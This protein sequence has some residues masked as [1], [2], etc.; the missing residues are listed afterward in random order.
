[1]TRYA[2]ALGS[3]VGRRLQHLKAAVE[4]ISSLGRIDGVSG[5]YET[6]PIGGPAQAP[7][8]NAV[9]G[10]ET[11]L[12]PEALLDRLRQI[13]NRRGRERMIRWGPRTLDL[14]IIGSDGPAVTDPELVIPHPR[15]SERRFVLE[16]LSDLWPDV[17]VN[18]G[19]TASEALAQ[20]GD[21]DVDLL[22]RNWAGSSPQRTGRYLVGAQ[23][24]WFLAIAVVMVLDG[25]LPD[26]DGLRLVGGLVAAAGGLLLLLSVRKLGPAVSPLPE[27][28]PDAELV[29]TGPY[30]H[31]RHPIYGGVVLVLSG[32]SLGLG[33]GLAALLTAGL[34]VFFW[35]KSEYEERQLRI[36]YSGYSAYRERV[37][38]RFIP[39]L[40]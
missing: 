17:L 12:I 33:S 26:F 5:L 18:G 27:P 14:D 37:T 15:A 21:Q 10:V 7:Y 35:F 29:E 24:I 11:E 6:E 2:I 23:F 38:R 22:A 32:A 9:V 19:L 4:S 34:A 8:L 36:A 1:M 13:E 28:L 3:N 25:S 40:F 31:A 39:F 16:P 30:A 20:V